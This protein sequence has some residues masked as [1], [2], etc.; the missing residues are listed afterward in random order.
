MVRY[1]GVLLVIGLACCDRVEEQPK[2]APVR[3]L[4]TP[5]EITT[6]EITRLTIDRPAVRGK[7]SE[8]PETVYEWDV[9]DQIIVVSLVSSDEPDKPGMLV[10][11]VNNKST[12]HAEFTYERSS[13]KFELRWLPERR[14]YVRFYRDFDKIR[15]IDGK[16]TLGESDVVFLEWDKKEKRV[17]VIDPPKPKT[18]PQKSDRVPKVVPG[19]LKVQGALETEIVRRVVRQRRREMKFCYEQQLQKNEKLAG[20][21]KFEFTISKTGSVVNASILESSLDD[22]TAEKCMTGKLRRWR[23]PKP[24]KGKSVT[25]TYPFHFSS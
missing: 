9:D 14:L 25:V 21:V 16:L 20:T 1:F 17:R 5:P 12:H 4:S 7:W 8:D 24:T 11:H 10:T 22:E 15:A 23:F 2:P 19:R 6:A 18:V 3:E 13:D